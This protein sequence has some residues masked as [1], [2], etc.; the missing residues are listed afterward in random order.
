MLQFARLPIKQ[1]QGFNIKTLRL[2]SFV[3]HEALAHPIVELIHGLPDYEAVGS[4]AGT[5]QPRAVSPSSTTGHPP[6]FKQPLD[7][8]RQRHAS[9]AALHQLGRPHG[10]QRPRGPAQAA[11]RIHRRMDCGKRLQ[12]RPLDVFHRSG[13]PPGPMALGIRFA[14]AASAEFD[15][16]AII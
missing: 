5:Q 2:N 1:P 16:A 15:D 12:Q 13:S 11:C 4:I 7:P 3:S 6:D 8:R 14:P 9:E 10:D